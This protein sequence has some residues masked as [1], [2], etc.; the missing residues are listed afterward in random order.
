MSQTPPAAATTPL[1]ADFDNVQK[2]YDLSDEFFA[3]FLDPSMTYSCA[4]F[5]TP[6]T[7]LADAQRAK[8][9]LSLG[10]CELKPG[11]RLLD[12]GCG[13]GATALRAA[14]K[15]GANVTG[16]TL[17]RN[18]F[19]HCT[20]LARGRDGVEFR[21]EGWET[22][23]MPVDRIVSIG[24]YEHF[25]REKY[26]AFF[27]KAR[28]LLPKTPGEGVMLLHTITLGKPSKQFSF[29]RFVHFMSTK[30]FPGGDVPPP[31][32]VV[33]FARTG[34]FEVE[35]VESLR[36][37]YAR[38]LDHWARNLEANH[39]KA[40]EVAGEDTYK[41]YMKYLV[42]CANYFRSGEVNVHQFKLRAA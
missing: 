39:Q 38:T 14:E 27:T 16:L 3:L 33:E 41:T 15:Y 26:P 13:W 19:D 31:E 30:I 8:I 9:D 36:P 40:V 2:H 21:L 32:R 42:D 23:Q 5:D 10:K 24:A 34:N 6:E 37:H 12:V 20:R 1:A 35:H 17:S 18:Q 22:F 11:M 4:K 25:G 29:L 7:S 28:S